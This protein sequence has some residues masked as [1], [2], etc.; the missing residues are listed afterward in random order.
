MRV[1]CDL[2]E[3]IAVLYVKGTLER[4]TVGRFRDAVASLG[5]NT[6]V[7]FDLSAVPFIDSAGLGALIGAVRRI[8]EMSGR[9]AVCSPRPSLDRVL[10]VVGVPRVVDVFPSVED[11]EAFLRIRSAFRF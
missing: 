11:A 7:I 4:T 10:Q 9:V 2:Q 5:A 1:V 3:A 6:D 8:R